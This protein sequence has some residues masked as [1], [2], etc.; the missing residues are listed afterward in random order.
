MAIGY[1]SGIIQIL[2]KRFP[3]DA[4]AVLPQVPA[5]TGGGCR[6][7]DALVMSLW[8]SRGLTLT[9]I[10]IKLARSDWLRELKD[11]SK[12]DPI[13]AYCDHWYIVTNGPEVARIEELPDTWGLIVCSDSDSKIVKKASKLDAKPMS[14]AFLAAILRRTMEYLV[15][16]DAERAAI[17]AARQ[18]GFEAGKDVGRNEAR[19]ELY[20][21]KQLRQSI[22]DFKAESGVEISEYHGG[23]VGEA[24]AVARQLLG[25]QG[26]RSQLAEVKGRTCRLRELADRTDEVAAD[27]L[28]VLGDKAVP[29]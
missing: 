9:G 12:A 16:P 29:S 27:L 23:D 6:I 24:F 28:K 19:G 25:Y 14:R 3:K 17:N 18:E 5:E 11:P 21:L 8:R 20:A 13:C 2:K 1:E 4:Y 26:L 7:A 22:A 15:P 10:E